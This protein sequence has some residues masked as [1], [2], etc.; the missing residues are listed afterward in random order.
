MFLFRERN[1]ENCD[2]QLVSI[3]FGLSCFFISLDVLSGLTFCYR[4][5][6]QGDPRQVWSSYPV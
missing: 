5:G 4:F 2:L 3:W 1:K 6:S